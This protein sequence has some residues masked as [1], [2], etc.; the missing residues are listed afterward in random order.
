MARRP[1]KGAEA[2]RRPGKRPGQSNRVRI[3]GGVHGGRKLRFPDAAGLR[4]TSDRVRETLFNWLQS[5]LPGASCLDLFSGSGALSLEAA[6]RGA[7]RVVM[8]DS[9]PV[10]VRQLKENCALLGL[11]SVTIE[12]ANALSWLEGAAEPFDI[13]FL[14]PP[15]A[16]DLLEACC[17]KLEAGG[18][19]ASEARIY[20]EMDAHKKLPHLPANW[21]AL[22]EKEAGQVAFYLF[23]RT[24]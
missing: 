21:Q 10:V 5:V 19:L 7:G 18:W 24:K 23:F 8:L 3:I 11:E 14:D 22:K 12:Q 6:S 1:G 2:R 20:I 4:P 9:A 16:E 13:V 17:E 15:F